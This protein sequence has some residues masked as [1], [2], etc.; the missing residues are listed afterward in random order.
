MPEF[1]IIGMSA[2]AIAAFLV[3]V[4]LATNVHAIGI[5]PARLILNYTANAVVTLNVSV[6]N[7]ENR[8]LPIR[9]F[10]GGDLASFVQ[11]QVTSATM[12]PMTQR[13]LN[14]ILTMPSSL[15]GPRRYDTRIG[16]VEVP[17][18]GDMLGAVA[19]IE[20]QLWVDAPAGEGWSPSNN[21]ANNTAQQNASQ[22]ACQP[23][24]NQTSIETEA[25]QPTIAVNQQL[26]ILLV[27]IGAAIGLATI[28]LA[29][30]K[31]NENKA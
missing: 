3:F 13:E 7:S 28:D 25:A 26:G 5:T 19:G 4:L 17:Q 8:I 21:T 1:V 9:T 10:V 23:C 24:S 31:K 30:P 27:A 15:A 6:L 18:G 2:K 22:C 11:C 29:L 16:A 14:C 12:D 20:M